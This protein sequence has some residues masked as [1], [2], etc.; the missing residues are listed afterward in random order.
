MKSTLLKI[1]VTPQLSMTQKQ[2]AAAV[3]GLAELLELEERHGLKPWKSNATTRLYRVSAIE[4]ALE[5]AEQANTLTERARKPRKKEI[6]PAFKETL[7]RA[8]KV[9]RRIREEWEFVK[10]QSD[11]SAAAE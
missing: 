2:A 5:R 1:D 3:G 10:N 8:K 11:Q 7:E 9:E 6:D 4:A